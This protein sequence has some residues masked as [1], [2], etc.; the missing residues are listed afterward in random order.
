VILAV[1]GWRVYEYQRDRPGPTQP[2][3]PAVPSTVNGSGGGGGV[4]Q[5]TLDTPTA[6]C[7]DG[8]LSYAANHQGACSH[9]GGVI[10]WYR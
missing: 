1:I 3:V 4:Q 5:P 10:T 6:E 7:A 9:H 8:S 2:G